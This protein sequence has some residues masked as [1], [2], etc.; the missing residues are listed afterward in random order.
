MDS[1]E[2]LEI[3]PKCQMQVLTFDVRN[4]NHGLDRCHAKTGAALHALAN[5]VE[6]LGVKVARK[7]YGYG[8]FGFTLSDGMTLK[9][10]GYGAS[11]KLEIRDIYSGRPGSVDTL[12][13]MITA[14]VAVLRDKP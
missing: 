7:G 1:G 13:K 11:A 8:N 3:C 12:T 4:G 5:A 14:L 9:I 2:G 10:G 6:P